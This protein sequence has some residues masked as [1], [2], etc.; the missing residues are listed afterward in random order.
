[1]ILITGGLGFV[2]VHTAAA[3]LSAGEK[4]VLTRHRFGRIPE[5]LADRI[6][7]GV[8]VEQIDVTDA[9]S[10]R[11][12]VSRHGVDGIIHLAAPPL[13]E[14]SIETEFRTNLQGLVSVLE[15]ARFANVKR[16]T[17]GSSIAVYRGLANGPFREGENLPMHSAIGVETFKKSFEILA[18]HYANRSGLE[19]AC[20][21]ISSVYGPL[22]SSMV[23]VPSR[24]VHAAVRGMKGPLPHAMFPNTFA[25]SSADFIFVE[26]CARGIRDLQLA[27]KLEHRT[28]NLGSGRATT[29]QEFAEAV[30]RVVPGA[31]IALEDGVGPHFRHDAF[32]DLTRIRAEVNFEPR[33]DV[34][35]A[36]ERYVAWLRQGNEH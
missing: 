13:S 15:A 23:N 20:I 1:M 29:A 24:I 35:H 33:F 21:R 27:S 18:D 26:D 6:D 17:I 36:V 16:V 30:R 34:N 3:L 8:F 11:E 9:D 7:S 32:E 10:L 5:F 19:I 4:V 22:Y 14:N 31:D 28:Y 12:L 2:G 25:E